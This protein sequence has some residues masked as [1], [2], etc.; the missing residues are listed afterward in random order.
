M[1]SSAPVSCA[2]CG[3]PGEG[4]FCSACGTPRAGIS[5]PSCGKTLSLTARFCSGCG[6][7]VGAAGTAAAHDRTPWIFAGARLAGLLAVILV[8]LARGS[9]RTVAAESADLPAQA[10]P[11]E[12]P[13]DISQMTPRERFNRLYNRVMQAAQSGDQATVTKEFFIRAANDYFPSRDIELLDYMELL[14]VFESSSRRFLPL[15]YSGMSP[16]ELDLKLRELRL[17]I[18]SRR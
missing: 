13:P 10:A 6:R 1:T 12:A 14:A 11:A 18:G 9:T 7:D 3:A 2:A 17:K 5:C 15:K 8:V 16:E 4:K